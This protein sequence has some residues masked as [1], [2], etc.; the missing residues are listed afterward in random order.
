MGRINQIGDDGAVIG[1]QPNLH[2]DKNRAADSE[3]KEESKDSSVLGQIEY[4]SQCVAGFMDNIPSKTLKNLDFAMTSMRKLIDK[5]SKAFHTGDWNEYGDISSLL[6][7]IE[8]GNTDYITQ[9]VDYHRNNI[10]GDITPE[11]I[12]AIYNTESRLELVTSIIKQ[13][14][15][16][17]DNITFEDCVEIDTTYVRKV[18]AYENSGEVSKVNYAALSYDS[19][20]NQSIS[21]YAF[22]ANKGCILLANIIDQKDAEV[23]NP[24]KKSLVEQLFSEVTEEI[25]CRNNSYGL[26]QSVEILEKTLYNYY[27]KRQDLLNLYHLLGDTG[28]TYLTRKIKTYQENLDDALRNV[29]RA[30]IGNQMYLSELNKLE[31]EKHYLLNIYAGMNNNS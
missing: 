28:S 15:Y 2:Y 14:Y 13:L 4:H 12:E 19:E 3:V 31:S 17:S 22:N 5:L 16:G 20:F 1:Y 10:T 8:G 26:Q 24:A 6:S 29:N 7:A 23:T 18:L 30:F 27:N 25:D 21:Q 9:F 11:L